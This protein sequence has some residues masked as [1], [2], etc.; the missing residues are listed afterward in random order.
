MDGLKEFFRRVVWYL[1]LFDLW[2]NE[3]IWNGWDGESIS[4]RCGKAQW[5]RI[6]KVPHKGDWVWLSLGSVVDVLFFWDKGRHCLEH[7]Q[8]DIGW[9]PGTR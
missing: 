7:I 2:W 8:W 9:S 4:S 5:R 3:N 6:E 1:Y